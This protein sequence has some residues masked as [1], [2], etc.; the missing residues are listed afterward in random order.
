MLTDALGMISAGPAYRRGERINWR[1]FNKFAMECYYVKEPGR[2]GFRKRR[3]RHWASKGS[4]EASVQKFL[5]QIRVIKT[6]E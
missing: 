6:N 3:K 4:F 2:R 1:L 5:D